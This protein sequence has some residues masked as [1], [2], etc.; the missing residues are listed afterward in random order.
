MDIS[1]TPESR[2]FVEEKVRSGQFASADDVV[3]SA[4][5]TVR[6]Q[7]ELTADDVQALRREIEMG[8]EQSKR[9]ESTPLDMAA[10]KAEVR[11]RRQAER[12]TA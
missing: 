2:R 1:L 3:N 5:A 9:G 7:E 11:R 10:I 6:A 8:L 12:K 4:L